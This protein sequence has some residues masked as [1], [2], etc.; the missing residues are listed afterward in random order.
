MYAEFLHVDTGQ[1]IFDNYSIHANMVIPISMKRNYNGATISETA[2][3]A[4][5]PLMVILLLSKSVQCR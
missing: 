5:S 3:S 2:T 4:A 1:E